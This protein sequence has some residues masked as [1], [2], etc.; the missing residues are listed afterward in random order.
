MQHT[1]P[2]DGLGPLGPEMAAAVQACVHCGFCLATCPTYQVLREEMDSPRGRIYLMKAALE[3]R[4]DMT[5]ALVEHIDRC[6]GCLACVTACPSGV[7]YDR[8]LMGFREHLERRR[9]ARPLARRLLR[10]VLAGVLPHPRRFR[11]AVRVGGLVRSVARRLPEALAGPLQL[12]PERIGSGEP[13][14]G[15]YAA[16][17][18]RRAR[19]VLLSGCVQQ[20]LAPSINRAAVRVLTHNGV[21]VL[22]PFGQGCCGALAMHSGMADLA[23]ALARRNLAALGNQDADAIVTTAAGCGSAMKEYALLFAGEPESELADRFARRVR[24]ISEFLVEL[25][26]VPPGPLEEPLRV[27]YHDACHLAHAQ[28]VREAPR[29]LLRRI[30][31]LELV[32]LPEPDICCG[33]AGTYNLEHPDVARALGRRKADSILATGAAAVVTGNIGCM[34]QIGAGL[35]E[36]NGAVPVWHTVELLERAYR[37]GRP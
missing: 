6:L 14:A 2:L 1:M 9:P 7:R 3:G 16:R 10:R 21:E 12:L 8:L 31:N 26:P 23:R 25:G 37:P 35:R 22:V 30:P 17:G 18:P 19:V 34:V 5:G 20:V 15:F 4:L 36:R 33:S 13:T 24:D 27:A 32:E 11:A 29:R 28:G